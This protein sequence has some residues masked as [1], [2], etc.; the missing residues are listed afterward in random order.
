M[1]MSANANW[2]FTETDFPTGGTPGEKLAYAWK[3]A[4]LAAAQDDWEPARVRLETGV[5]ELS[6][7]GD[8]RMGMDDS[9]GHESM[10]RSGAALFYLKVAL[11]RFGCLGRVETFP[12]LDRS[13]LVARVFF[14][15]GRHREPEEGVLFGAMTRDTDNPGWS[16]ESPLSD[17]MLEAL[18]PTVGGDKAWLE[19]PQSD[20]GRQLLVGVAKAEAQAGANR[21]SF[22]TSQ[23]GSAISRNLPL[24]SP[25][26]TFTVH[27]GSAGRISVAAS[28]SPGKQAAALAVIK[29]KTDDKHG[30]VAAGQVMAQARLQAQVAGVRWTRF[31]PAFQLRR[32]RE[33]VRIMIG[34]KGFGQ[35]LIGFGSYRGEMNFGSIS[36]PIAAAARR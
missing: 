20:Y 28:E 15:F 10:L 26:V 18:R 4:A 6:A 25:A 29:T 2:K 35:A 1:G 32:S 3:C 8:D 12:D 21:R 23:S 9:D 31:S 5:I 13:E 11:K 16:G 22:P 24:G 33:E 17:A 14:G 34:R 36:Q 30:W 7:V 27:A 19:I